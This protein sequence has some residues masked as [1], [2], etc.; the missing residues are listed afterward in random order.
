[1]TSDL[2]ATPLVTL[3][4][5][6]LT[7]PISLEGR[8]NSLDSDAVTQAG[9]ALTALA[10]GEIDAG[11]VLLVGLGKNFCA[12]GNVPGFA[13]AE[14]RSEHVRELADRLHRVIRH[15]DAA[16][17]P[18]VAAVAGWAA[19]AGLS[20]ALAADFSVG[21]PDTRLLAAYPGIGLSP[22][23]GMSWR[24]PRAI[25]HSAASAFILGN[26]PMDGERAYRIGMITT[27][28]E[29]DVPTEARTLAV[30]LAAGPRAS[31]AAT[32]EL[33]RRSGDRTLAQQLDA[34]RDSIAAL[35]VSPDG[36]EGVDAFVAK[37][38]PRFGGA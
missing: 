37:R 28:T 22:D 9:T 23:G 17:V 19:G 34:E 25:G 29:E 26:E 8:G 35:A 1:M 10:A 12:G 20:L 6:V 24:L 15:L 16:S 2:T 7:I 38:S 4:D 21:G 5:G 3:E 13:A 36:V 27:F 31:H 30:R 11:A 14:D 33:L 18:V 32:K